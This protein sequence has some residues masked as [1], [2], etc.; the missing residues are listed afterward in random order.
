MTEPPT[1]PDPIDPGHDAGVDPPPD[2]ETSA[3]TEGYAEDS[4]NTEPSDNTDADSHDPA[5]EFE[6]QPVPHPPAVA[7]EDADT[8]TAA[9]AAEEV[10]R[11][12]SNPGVG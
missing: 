6:G 1:L 5:E 10:D 2:E 4:G 12:S 8:V 11:R 3:V 9:T 7:T